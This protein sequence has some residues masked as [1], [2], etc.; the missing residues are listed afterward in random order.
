MLVN[1][2]ARLVLA[3]VAIAA[4]A[5]GVGL[6]TMLRRPPSIPSE[7]GSV[8]EDAAAFRELVGRRVED[9]PPL[10]PVI[11]PALGTDSGRAPQPHSQEAMFVDEFRSR[12]SRILTDHAA[13]A[14]RSYAAVKATH[15]LLAR[16]NSELPALDAL[17]VA[18]SLLT[19][20]P[21]D[22]IMS[23]LASQIGALA[24]FNILD[25]PQEAQDLLAIL[26]DAAYSPAND[27]QVTGI[28]YTLGLVGK[29]MAHGE[30]GG[31]PDL[32]RHLHAVSYR[33]SSESVRLAIAANIRSLGPVGRMDATTAAFRDEL[34]ADLRYRQNQS[35]ALALSAFLR[36]TRGDPEDR[37]E[38]IA[39]CLE[40]LE[41]NWISDEQVA[42][43]L[44]TLK[45]LGADALAQAAAVNYRDGLDR[46]LILRSI[47]KALDAH[48]QSP[49][50]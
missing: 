20:F 28:V 50:R 9:A 5:A 49:I 35:D 3:C 33:T 19:E 40:L 18:L 23:T 46:D 26:L 42:Q 48:H 44:G 10:Q 34:V 14:A 8:A 27:C 30:E 37:Q 7:G 45:F 6:V 15:E 16:A 31:V 13:G 12:I 29:A 47:Q 11:Q 1:S 43:I 4:V 24:A 36:T 32:S 25:H 2:T 17:L 41:Q 22:E 38:S 21:G 39:I